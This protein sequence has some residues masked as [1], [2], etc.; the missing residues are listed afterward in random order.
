MRFLRSVLEPV[1]ARSRV[2][3]RVQNQVQI[4]GPDPGQIQVLRFYDIL[5]IFQSSGRMN[6]ILYIIHQIS[7]RLGLGWVP[8][9][10]LSDYPP[11]R[12]TPGT[13]TLPPLTSCYRSCMVPGIKYGRGAQIGS[14]THLGTRLV[15]V[16]RYDRRI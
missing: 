5:K 10:P 11:D 13:P 7:L 8:G 15:A 16:L 12:T 3:S 1:R 4:Q 2:R 6:L 14:S 9:I